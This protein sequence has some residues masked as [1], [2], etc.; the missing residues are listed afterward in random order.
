MYT[1][2]FKGRSQR[3][4]QQR[5][6]R[7]KFNLFCEQLE[8]RQLLTTG[9][10]PGSFGPIYLTYG[11]TLNQVVNDGITPAKVNIN[12]TEV[13]G[14]WT[15][16][17]ASNPT[18][19]LTQ[20]VLDA[21][22]H[23][24]DLTAT[25]TPTG[26][27]DNYTAATVDVEVAK[28]KIAIVANSYEKTYGHA[29]P[30]LT[31]TIYTD[32][33]PATGIDPTTGNDYSTE[34]DPNTGKP[35]EV[36]TQLESTDLASVA[37]TNALGGAAA[38]STDADLLAHAGSH[39]INPTQISDG[40]A[41]TTSHEFLNNF[42]VSYAN[43]SL[44]VTPATL[45]VTA[46]S[47]TKT[48][49]DAVSLTKFTTDGLVNGDSVSGV[50]LTS[51]GAAATA[52]VSGSPYA[53]VASDAAGSGLDNYTISYTNGSLTVSQKALTVTANSATKTYGDTVTFAGTEFTTD[54]LVNG[55]SV[56]GVTLTSD[57]AAATA[58]VSGSPYAIVASDAAG[59]GLDNYTISYTNGSLTVSQRR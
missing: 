30:T 52:P 2:I 57:G 54:G 31:D 23:T 4:Q 25:F 27:T 19:D 59:S 56:S 47:A 39:V 34:T 41:G 36:H 15:F 10:I 50:T 35:Y 55:D 38:A 28:A 58:P 11:Q 53:I 1:S 29:N 3:Q 22:S 6:K 45:T 14:T 43:G 32:L 9:T 42:D 13:E 18:K 20:A 44:S 16:D 51:D 48:Y 40:D 7:T 37:Y 49:G 12:G 26:T 33:G 46:N 24:T 5:R 17:D 21:G 8:G